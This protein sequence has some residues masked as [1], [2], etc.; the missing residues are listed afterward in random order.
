[1]EAESRVVVEADLGSSHLSQL[2]V[3]SP[4]SAVA[5]DSSR[6][7]ASSLQGRGVGCAVDEL[8]SEDEGYAATPERCF[9]SPVR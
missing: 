1:M 6:A 7:K 5:Q 3:Q 9:W 8:L 2:S 4:E